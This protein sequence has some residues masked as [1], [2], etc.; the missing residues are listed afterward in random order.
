MELTLV[1]FVFKLVFF[2]FY[3]SFVLKIPL[4]ALYL[5]YGLRV[6]VL[7]YVFGIEFILATLLTIDSHVL[8]NQSSTQVYSKD[9]LPESNYV[10][11]IF[12]S[13]VFLFSLLIRKYRTIVLD[14]MLRRE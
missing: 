2:A 8:L 10:F 1:A 3:T 5:I 11:S 7:I 9:I 6:K 12:T 13:S 14:N 4:L